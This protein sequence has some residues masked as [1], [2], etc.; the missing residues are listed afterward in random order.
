MKKSGKVNFILAIITAVAIFI[1]IF[2]LEKLISQK[3]SHE[4]VA[5]Y[6][7]SI[8]LLNDTISE[9]K[10][11]IARYEEE[12]NNINLERESIREKIQVIIEEN[13]KVDRVLANGDWNDNIKFLTEFLSKKDSLGE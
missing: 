11:D 5:E 3:V 4:A 12:I 9:L 2:A 8:R 1:A 10:K 13:E 7:E 6:T